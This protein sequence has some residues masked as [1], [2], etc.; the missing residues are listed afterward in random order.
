MSDEKNDECQNEWIRVSQS[1]EWNGINMVNGVMR[2]QNLP[3]GQVNFGWSRAPH[4][5]SSKR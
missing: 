5:A 4:E 2:S 1:N 3:G